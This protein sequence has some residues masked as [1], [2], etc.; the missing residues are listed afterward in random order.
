MLRAHRDP[1]DRPY[2]RRVTVVADQGNARD[3]VAANPHS[4]AIVIRGVPRAALLQCPCG[5]GET[6]SINL[7]PRVGKAWRAYAD[8]GTI[9]LLPSVWRTSGCCSHFCVWQNDVV[10]CGAD[11]ADD[12][13]ETADLPTIAALFRRR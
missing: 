8:D 5:C 2:F 1:S 3:A 4:L 12:W 7:D 13:L 11:W 6:L 10:W 9:S